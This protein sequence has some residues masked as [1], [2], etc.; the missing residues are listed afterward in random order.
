MKVTYW[1]AC[2]RDREKWKK[3]VAEKAKT[4]SN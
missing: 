4:F 3:E 1:T 2:V